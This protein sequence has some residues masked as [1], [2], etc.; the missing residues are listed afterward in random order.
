VPPDDALVVAL[1]DAWWPVEL[2]RLTAPRLLVTLS[3]SLQI[4]GAPSL[5]AGAPLLHSACTL[6]GADGYVTEQRALWTEAG[7][8]LALNQQ[9]FALVK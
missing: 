7:A 9:T 8:L 6:A 5:A 2:T 3:F 4:L 1:A